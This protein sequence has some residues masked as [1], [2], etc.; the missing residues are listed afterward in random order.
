MRTP[1]LNTTVSIY[2]PLASAN[3]LA[4]IANNAR[5]RPSQVVL[6]ALTDQIILLGLESGSLSWHDMDEITR[7]EWRRN[8]ARLNNRCMDVIRRG[9]EEEQKIQAAQ[10][11][12]DL[13]PQPV[14]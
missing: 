11:T 10:P 4:A 8:L 9:Q 7:T 2:V 5:R 12:L 13:S 3:A 14:S 6:Q 1:T